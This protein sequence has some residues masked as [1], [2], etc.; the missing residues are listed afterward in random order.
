MIYLN[1]VADYVLQANDSLDGRVSS[2][3]NR[4]PE[5]IQRELDKRRIGDRYARNGFSF[6]AFKNIETH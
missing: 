5:S 1:K 2:R 4:I 3:E 6:I